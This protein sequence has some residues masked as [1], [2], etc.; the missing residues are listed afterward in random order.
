[1]DR[2]FRLTVPQRPVPQERLRDDRIIIIAKNP[3]LHSVKCDFQNIQ[4]LKAGGFSKAI[5]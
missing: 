2:D 4:K 1:L 5:E 3:N